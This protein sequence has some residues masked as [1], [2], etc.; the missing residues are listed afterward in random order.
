VIVMIVMVIAGWL[1]ANVLIA[2]W[3]FRRWTVTL[4]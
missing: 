4:T 3:L 1:M 2:G